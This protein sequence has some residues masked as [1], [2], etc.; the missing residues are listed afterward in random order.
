MSKR[1][2]VEQ[3]R[4]ALNAEM[5][6][7]NANRAATGTG[8]PLPAAEPGEF[9]TGTA[10]IRLRVSEV[11]AYD[12]NPRTEPNGKYAEIRESMRVR[13]LDHRLVVTKRPGASRYMLAKGGKT[14]LEILQELAAEDPRFEYQD[15]DVVPYK[16]ESELLVAHIVENNQR[17]GMSFWDTANGYLKLRDKRSRELGRDISLREFSGELKAQGLVPGKDLL[18]EGEFLVKRLA[19]LGVLAKAITRNGVRLH[20]R[21]QC[22]AIEEL[23]SRLMPNRSGEDFQQAY[24]SWL[25]AFSE[26]WQDLQQDSQPR[27]IVETDESASI[28]LDLRLAAAIHREAAQW[29]SLTEIELRAALEALAED[30]KVDGD[31]LRAA[32]QAANLQGGADPSSGAALPFAPPSPLDVTE[33]VTDESA[34][35]GDDLS[36]DTHTWTED[37]S[38]GRVPHGLNGVTPVPLSAVASLVRLDSKGRPIAPEASSLA[39]GASETS[40]EP[41]QGDL[42][43]TTTREQAEEALQTAVLSLTEF[44]GITELL[45]AAPGMPLTY[46]MDLPKRPLGDDAR[47][48]AVQAWWFLANLA[49]QFTSHCFQLSQRHEGQVIYALYDTGPE[50]FRQIASSEQSLVA[51]VQSHLGG[52]YATEGVQVLDL[53]TDLNN[54]MSELA[55]DLV[56]CAAGFRLH[57][58]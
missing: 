24:V 33:E 20:L 57:R 7:A 52:V 36:D 44:A 34:E 26:T 56:R 27:Y 55:L 23:T 37:K 18:S 31:G 48:Y 42:P 25:V 40:P 9:G 8:N 15:F 19:P 2:G 47:D 35:A 13:G 58:G 43:G 39:P 6:A 45:R 46:F 32:L 53:L 51:V 21:P 4:A 3:M 38:S 28:G 16:S 29:L 1:M 5:Q 54:P 30:R 17:D 14:R 50:G 12:D 22:L 49:G 41:I 10:I 11:D